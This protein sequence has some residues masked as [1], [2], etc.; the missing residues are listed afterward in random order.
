MSSPASIE[1]GQAAPRHGGVED[2]DDLVVAVADDAHRGLGVMD[3]ELALGQDH[4]ASMVGRQHVRQS[5]Q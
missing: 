3:A 2:G 4:E 5:T 1:F